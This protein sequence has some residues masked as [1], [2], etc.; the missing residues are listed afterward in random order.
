MHKRLLALALTATISLMAVATDAHTENR[1]PA[2][3]CVHDI[4][5]LPHLPVEGTY[6]TP[7]AI[8]NRNQI[9][10]TLSNA[11]IGPAQAFIWD[12]NLGMRTAVSYTHLTLPTIL[13]V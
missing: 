5:G 8:N 2:T 13:R 7:A 12:P 3:Y 1:Q 11:A 4:G 10:G 9:V 6:V